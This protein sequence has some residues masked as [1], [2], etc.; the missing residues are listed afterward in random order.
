MIEKETE[1]LQ[2]ETGKA[3]AEILKEKINP[4]TIKNTQLIYDSAS[5]MLKTWSAS[6]L[7]VW[8]KVFIRSFKAL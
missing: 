2:I 1:E 4:L 3:F 5:K 7:Q 8:K 6:S